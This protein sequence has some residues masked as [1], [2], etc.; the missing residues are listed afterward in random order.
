[1]PEVTPPADDTKGTGTPP[2]GTPPAK[3]EEKTFTQSQLDAI[4]AD[5]VKRAVPADYETLKEK[6]A[7]L[8][9]AEEAAKTELQRAQDEAAKAKTEGATAVAQ[10]AQ[11][12]RT[13]RIETEAA[14]AGALNPDVV[15]AL[16]AS[17]AAITVADGK[18]VGAK[19]AIEALKAA[20]ETA[21][22]FGA[23]KTGLPA[24]NG[25]QFGGVDNKTLDEQIAILEGQGKHKEARALKVQKMMS[26]GV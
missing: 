23:A 5:R 15:V 21:F 16:L 24:A 2:E 7:K 4:I 20:P 17:N 19:E 18:V 1:M 25:G 26:A 8:D 11:M 22:L 14:R 10:A 9:A 12:V 6:A 3:S 13:S